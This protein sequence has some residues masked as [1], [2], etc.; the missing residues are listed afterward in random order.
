MARDGG[1]LTRAGH[2]EAGC[3]LARIAGL[4]PSAVIVE[5]LNDD[6]TMSRRPDLEEFSKKHDI[7]IG[8]IADLIEYR[9]LNETTIERV[10][11][12]KLPTSHGEFKLLTYRDSID[13]L[14]H[15]ALINGEIEADTP[16]LVR[17]HL[18][19]TF[20]DL[21]KSE[22]SVNRSF[23]LED[24]MARIAKDGGVL[25]LLGKNETSNDLVNKVKAFEREDTGEVLPPATWQGTSRNVG[26]G[27]QILADVGV[28]KMRLLS[29]YKK[30]HSLS[31]F[32]LELVEYVE[33]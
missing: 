33:E 12:C 28:T 14:V 13:D 19:N 31:G 8:T 22:R 3:D 21:L 25:V 30:Y 5:I 27:S 9:N 11:E 18:Q 4:E 2:T 24:G 6:G 7:K 23:S 26:I 10:A 29:S 32:G 20:T 15:F 16:T 1:V 17:V